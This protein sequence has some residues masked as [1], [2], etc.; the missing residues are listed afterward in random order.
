MSGR[1]DIQ[2]QLLQVISIINAKGYGL[3]DVMPDEVRDYFQN[4]TALKEARTY[5][6]DIESREKDLQAEN[7]YLLIELKS[8][9]AKIDEQPL[10]FKAMNVDLQQSQ[11]QIDYYKGLA[12]DAQIRAERY[13]RKL[14][15]AFKLQT[16][17]DDDARKIQRLERDLIDREAAIYKLIVENRTTTAMINH[18]NQLEAETTETIEDHEK[19]SKAHDSL[20]DI[21]E[22]DSMTTVEAFN[23]NSAKLL[24]RI[25]LSDQLHSTIASELALLHS[26]YEHTFSILDVY[27]SVFQKLSDPTSRIIPSIPQSLDEIM[28]AANDKL[29]SWQHVSADLHAHNSVQSEVLCQV[30]DMVNVA[31]RIYT[32][33][34]SIRDFVSGFLD[35]LSSDPDALTTTKGI[36]RDNGKSVST[37]VQGSISPRSSI[38]SFASFAKRFSMA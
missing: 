26:F 6:K 20:I 17:A 14:A 21:L 30:D 4:M 27:L 19:V 10:E 33:L 16:T 5:I 35:R 9:Q 15:E 18:Y 24:N 25:D 38:S 23:L 3:E 7:A 34:E 13:Q 28:D 12:D 22:Q 2:K 36:G 32:S 29:Y 1:G 37:L 31:A 11:H 8:K